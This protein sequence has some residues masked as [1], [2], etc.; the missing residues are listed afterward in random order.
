MMIVVA[1][2]ALLAM[3]ATEGGREIIVILVEAKAKSPMKLNWTLSALFL[4]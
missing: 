3:K 1:G 4:P 2:I